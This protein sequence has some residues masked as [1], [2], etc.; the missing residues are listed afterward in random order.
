MKWLDNTRWQHAKSKS[1]PPFNNTVNQKFFKISFKESKDRREKKIEGGGGGRETDNYSFQ[2]NDE[3]WIFFPSSLPIFDCSII[4]E[5]HSKI[6]GVRVRIDV[7]TE[8]KLTQFT[9]SGYLLCTHVEKS[10]RKQIALQRSAGLSII[11]SLK[12]STQH[13]TTP[14][15]FLFFFTSYFFFK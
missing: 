2:Q 13:T 7:G 1:F 15:F 6:V 5:K 14:V 3:K 9:Y 8:G 11:F 12:N 4:Q 10:C